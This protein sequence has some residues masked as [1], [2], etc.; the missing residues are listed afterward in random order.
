[1][2][3]T[4]WV[5]ITATLA[6]LL[7]GCE[8]T[9]IETET[10]VVMLS[11][12]DRSRTRT[13]TPNSFTPA[14]S[15]SAELKN[16]SDT[17]RAETDGSSI[18]FESVKT[19]SYTITVTGTLNGQKV[20][21]GTGSITV[22]ANAENTA[23]VQL[24]AVENAGT[25]TVSVTFD[26]SEAVKT[27]GFF[28]DMYNQGEFTFEFYRRDTNEDGSTT[29]TLLTA[30]QKASLTATSYTFTADDIP[31]SEG[32]N[33]F[34]KIKQ[35][36][37]LVMDF[38]F[39][40]FNVYA[41]Q[42]S[43]ADKNDENTFKITATNAPVYASSIH[44]TA[45][46][47]SEDPETTVTV[48]VTGRGSDK[49]VLYKTV[50]VT[51]YDAASESV[52]S[53]V[54]LNGEIEDSANFITHTF[55]GLTSGKKYRV[56]V[57]GTTKRGKKTNTSSADVTT[58]VLV[59]GIKADE[60]TSQT[61]SYNSSLSLTADVLP[62]DATI[63]TVEWSTDNSESLSLVPMGNELLA[64]GN[65]PGFATLTVSSTDA[66][67]NGE[68]AVKT[69]G[70]VKVILA[71]PEVII[72]TEKDSGTAQS[73]L[74]LTWTAVEWADTYEIWRS[75]NDGEAVFLAE[76]EN[77]VYDDKDI[78]AGYSYS[79][80]VKAKTKLSTAECSYDSAFSTLS[81]S[82][83]PVKPTITLVQPKME[84][85]KLQI[86][87]GTSP[88]PE[89]ITVTPS[90][91]AVLTTGAI[92]GAVSMEWYV[93]G[94]FVKKGTSVELTSSMP[95]VQDM[96]ADS[97]A[98]TLVA[99]DADGKKSSATIYFRVVAVEDTGVEEFALSQYIEVG[100]AG[101]SIKTNVLP[102]DATIQSITY[103]S[104]D[105]SVATV[106]SS[107]NITIL[108]NGSVTFTATSVSGYKTE[109]TT[110]FYNAVTEETL[111]SLVTGWL[112]TELNAANNSFKYG[113]WEHDWWTPSGQTYTNTGITIKTSS[114]GSQSAGSLTISNKTLGNS[115][116]GTIT[117]STRT[118]LSLWAKNGGGAG[119]LGTD[120]LQYVAHDGTGVISL[121]LPYG[122]GTATI[123]FPTQLDVI[124]K[125]GTYKIYMS[126]NNTSKTYSYSQYPI[127]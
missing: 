93:N 126:R 42:I 105:T 98:L 30:P 28:K 2:K 60:I 15:Y 3:R 104:S 67:K 9:L 36:D 54:S 81:D 46:Y 90:K 63:N 122:Q 16:D 113:A 14:D 7:A 11:I 53:K 86:V 24:E 125:S 95:Q 111:M 94:K 89:D 116:T 41:G 39:A 56:E 76:T 1:M 64:F 92:E 68:K 33:G 100:T 107:G 57:I 82:F 35:G 4:I 75:V 91:P 45:E 119:N 59:T 77:D 37:E 115:S 19:G 114:G 32:F 12:D 71:T 87:E 108:K 73:Y 103:S 50:S 72:T 127:F 118:A 49:K 69:L 78:T 99:T 106:D 79:Y 62:A 20:S 44:F 74:S 88:S 18:T 48:S 6:L 31:A 40:V 8:V 83:T 47:G 38:G 65:K 109:K 21:E 123:T 26:W 124:N 61:L 112:K 43:V 70:T 97:N 121:E 13:V 5:I 110:T 66:M 25:G 101:L 34:F 51:L 85:L 27:E 117:A 102:Y 17:Y 29:D 120:P 96:D 58:K 23:T 22:N 84:S 55:T 10:A 52:V 80:K